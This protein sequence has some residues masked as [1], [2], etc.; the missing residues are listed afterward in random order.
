MLD[1]ILLEAHEAEL[2]AL[3]TT[4]NGAEA[5]A[6]LLFGSVEIGA[7][8]WTGTPRRRL[9]SHRVEPVPAE[10]RVSASAVH[11]T[12]STRS[13]VRLL[14]VAETEGLTLGIVHT[15][16]GSHAFFSDQDEANEQDLLR[17]VANRS[18]AGHGF[19]SMVLGGDGSICAR[20]HRA[21]G[22]VEVARRVSVVGRSVRLYGMATRGEADGSL[23]RQ[24]R[25]FGPSFNAIVRGLRA[26]IVGGG[27]TGSPTA[28]LLARLGVGGLLVVDDDVVEETNLNRVHGSRRSDVEACVPKV[29]VIAREIRAAGLEV[30]VATFKGWVG[31]PRVRDALR[32]C[33]VVFG[34]T[35][36]HDGRLFLNRLAYFYGIP[37]IDMG[38]RMVPA[39]EGHPYEMAARVTLAGPGVPCL[40][41]RG[42]IDPR[43]AMEEALRRTDREEYEARKAEAYVLGGGDPAPAVVTFTTE[44]AC[45][46]VNE[47][48]QALTGFRGDG[49]MRAGR[50]RRFDAVED[51]STTCS[52]RPGCEICGG[53]GVWGRADVRPF[54]YRAG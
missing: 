46:A 8:P 47:L 39:R 53:T 50:L 16:P 41:C 20:V 27:G 29:D 48:L 14:K 11:V 43:I 33:D 52:P 21:A 49:G 2:R 54:L 28:M 36:D 45:M 35:D 1:V 24:A 10:D 23:D 51:R 32:S 13:F 40:M 37:L 7:D 15:H 17:I 3:L 42:V 18:G 31:D 22:A 19:A 44:T 26:G 38:L 5:S 25:L 34:C 4:L 9:V 12:W 30:E 6:Y